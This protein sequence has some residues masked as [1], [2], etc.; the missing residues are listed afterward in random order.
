[1]VRAATFGDLPAICKLMEEMHASGTYAKYPLQI[2]RKFKPL[3]MELMRSGRGCALVSVVHDEITGFLLGMA[4]SLCH[5]FDVMFATDVFFYPPEGDVDLVNIMY[6]FQAWAK[7]V[8]GVALIRVTA[9]AANGHRDR[10]GS[11]YRQI[12]MSPDAGVFS[13]EI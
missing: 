3:V 8:D 2:E 5:V 10:L 6:E 7:S 11:A 13:M 4:D 1:M 12:G 9:P